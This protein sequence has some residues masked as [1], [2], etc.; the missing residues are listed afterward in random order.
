[1]IETPTEV[2]APVQ[3]PT[4][5]SNVAIS[6]EEYV[7]IVYTKNKK[8]NVLNHEQ[9]RRKADHQR[10][11]RVQGRI[12]KLLHQLKEAKEELDSIGTKEMRSTL[13]KIKEDEDYHETTA[14]S[15]MDQVI[16]LFLLIYLKSKF[17]IKIIAFF[18]CSYGT[19][20]KRMALD[21]NRRR[22]HIQ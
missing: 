5:D 15:L 6:D 16:P 2:L 19:T 3:C 21:G 17:T 7:D 20:K 11:R 13:R 1:M 12:E 14:C 10:D 8:R 9:G 18:I 4:P 22:L